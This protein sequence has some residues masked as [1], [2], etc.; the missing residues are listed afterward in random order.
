MAT[1]SKL[2]FIDRWKIELSKI[3]NYDNFKGDFT[4]LLDWHLLQK[5]DQK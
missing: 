1:T 4:E 2:P 3:P 5:P